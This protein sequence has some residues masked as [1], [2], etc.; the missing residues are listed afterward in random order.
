MS[1]KEGGEDREKTKAA[2]PGLLSRRANWRKWS[3]RPR[4][5][6]CRAQSPYLC[7]NPVSPRRTLQVHHRGEGQTRRRRLCPPAPGAAHHRRNTHHRRYMATDAGRVKKAEEY[8]N[9]A[10][11]SFLKSN[12]RAV[13]EKKKEKGQSLSPEYRW[14]YEGSNWTTKSTCT[15]LSPNSTN[16]RATSRRRSVSS[17]PQYACQ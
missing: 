16:S 12:D 2:V 1:K 6:S 3:T 14:L 9:A 17:R 5:R 15:A 4:R 7:R 8:L 10:H 11:W 13:A